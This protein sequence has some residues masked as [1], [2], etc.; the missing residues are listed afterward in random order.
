ME[1][2]NKRLAV[3][4]DR[5]SHLVCQRP[6]ATSNKR[7]EMP[8][9]APEKPLAPELSTRAIW[10]EKLDKGGDVSPKGLEQASEEVGDGDKSRPPPDQEKSDASAKERVFSSAT[11]KED[12][13]PE[14]DTSY[15]VERGE[16][17][18]LVRPFGHSVVDLFKRCFWECVRPCCTSFVAIGIGKMR[19]SASPSSVES[20]WHPKRW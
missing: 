17:L 7:L 15:I 13:S 14:K 19:S 8:I 4:R 12:N 11:Y 5:R 3:E 6:Q 10:F 9:G 20:V 18:T 2:R 16:G 1:E